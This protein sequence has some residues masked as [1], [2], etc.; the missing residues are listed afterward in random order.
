VFLRVDEVYVGRREVFLWN[1]PD[2][3]FAFN[4]QIAIDLVTNLAGQMEERRRVFAVML[5][6]EPAFAIDQLNLANRQESFLYVRFYSGFF[7]PELLTALDLV[8]DLVR[9]LLSVIDGFHDG[10]H[11]VQKR[12]PVSSLQELGWSY[13]WCR[14]EDGRA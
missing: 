12:S 8:A 14:R 3:D 7:G 11:V 6:I 9:F 2:F 10:L 1:V 4:S 13:C 5:N